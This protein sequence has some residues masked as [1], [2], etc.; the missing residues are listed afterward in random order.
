MAG[1]I[2][3]SKLQAKEL[4]KKKKKKNCFAREF[5]LGWDEDEQ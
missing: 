3:C 5:Q 2:D 4:K 1:A